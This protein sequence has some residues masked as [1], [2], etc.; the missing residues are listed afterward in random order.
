MAW[1]EAGVP[2]AVALA[3]IGELFDE[4]EDSTKILTLKS[5]NRRVLRRWREL[6]VLA[7]VPLPPT[8]APASSS[9]LEALAAS[10]P[11][12]LP[13]RERWASEILQTPTDADAVA[14]EE[15]LQQLDRRMLEEL[16]ATLPEASRAAIASKAESALARLGRA[17]DVSA[18]AEARTALIEQ[19]V[20]R[21]FGAPRLSLVS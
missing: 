9:G 20:R 16:L 14:T 3:A 18:A 15:R 5:C 12:D 10:L 6:G 17:L 2:L 8:A 4:L 19:E 21:R 13:D 11:T 1:F 7:A